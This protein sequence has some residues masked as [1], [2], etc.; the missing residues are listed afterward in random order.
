MGTEREAAHTKLLDAFYTRHPVLVT[1]V[2]TCF[3][4]NTREPQ[5]NADH[6]LSVVELI[7]QRPV[8]AEVWWYVAAPA[9]AAAAARR[10]LFFSPSVRVACG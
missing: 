4:E 6:I 9:P 2:Y 10:P 3:V 5:L 1:A 7:E 8:L